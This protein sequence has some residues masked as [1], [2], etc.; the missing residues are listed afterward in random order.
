MKAIIIISL[1]ATVLNVSARA[2]DIEDSAIDSAI[3]S[4][5]DDQEQMLEVEAVEESGST[6]PVPDSD[7]VKTQTQAPTA[8]NIDVNADVNVPE[9]DYENMNIQPASVAEVEGKIKSKSKLNSKAIE[10]NEKPASLT[11]VQV[12]LN[13]QSHFSVPMQSPSS[14]EIIDRSSIISGSGPLFQ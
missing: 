8:V 3:D 9:N 2:Q 1:I 14:R 13:G 6:Q 10:R 11:N 4:A 7:P 5:T 12:S